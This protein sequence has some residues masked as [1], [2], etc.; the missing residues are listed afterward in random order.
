V[1]DCR[2]VVIFSVVA[3]PLCQLYLTMCSLLSFN[4]YYSPFAGTWV[5]KQRTQY[6]LMCDGKPSSMTP[7]RVTNLKK[8]GF[9][10][11]KR[12]L[13]DW[14][15]RLNELLQYKTEYGDCLVPN[16][17][18]PN[19]QLGTWV[20]HQRAQYRKLR[21][22][23]NSPMTEERV[24]ALEHVG[25]VW[26][27]SNADTDW[28][29][30]VAELRRYRQHHGNCL[31]P[32]KYPEN[33]KLG[34]W[35]GKQRKHYR[36]FLDG[37]PCNMT[38][39]RIKILEDLGFVW[40]LRSLV[41]WDARL[42]ELKEY[43]AAHGNCLV[44]QQYPENPQLGTWVSNQRK[45]YRLMKEDKPSPMTPERVKKLEEFGF[46]WSI[47]SHDSH[48]DS[49]YEELRA[50][51]AAH[52]GSVDVNE[53]EDMH[54]AAWCT[55]QRSQYRM[56]QQRRPSTMSIDRKESLEALG[57]QWSTTTGGDNTD[58]AN[59]KERRPVGVFHRDSPE[60]SGC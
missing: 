24:K 27:I 55:Y 5:N 51:A 57:F 40:T 31:V 34:A 56:L 18:P 36:L 53:D 59:D 48:W 38:F 29:K 41:D 54:L 22:G 35:V 16:K 58:N 4:Y 17:F 7:D 12:D 9:V 47:F 28:V 8:L 2:V 23:K 33:A 49:R 52:E 13:V 30:R 25:F 37:K 20:M 14:H 6:K 10:W 1:N 44:P 26:A 21:E 19:V 46:V 42:E 50:Y 45:Q 32:N 11:S 43:Q 15:T 60:S 39:D 3:P